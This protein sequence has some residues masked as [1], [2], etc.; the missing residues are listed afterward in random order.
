MGACKCEI[1][2]KSHYLGYKFTTFTKLTFSVMEFHCINVS[3]VSK[4]NNDTHT[5]THTHTHSWKKDD[6]DTM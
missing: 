4:R 6:F 2:G 3:F 5:W 1:L